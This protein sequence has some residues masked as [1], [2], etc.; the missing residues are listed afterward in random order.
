MGTV[1]HKNNAVMLRKIRL[2][3]RNAERRGHYAE[4]E[5][6]TPAGMAVS[7]K[8]A[9]PRG[10]H[11]KFVMHNLYE[12]IEQRQKEYESADDKQKNKAGKK[13]SVFL[14]PPMGKKEHGP[15]QHPV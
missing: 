15:G 1:F 10:R 13:K 14:F 9:K 3:A 5:Q 11:R 4:N 2:S 6:D 7:L 12:I 8:P